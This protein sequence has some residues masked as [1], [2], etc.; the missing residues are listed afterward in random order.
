MLCGR[1]AGRTKQWGRCPVPGHG[2]Y[3][4]V[5]R[6]I[7]AEPVG[8]A[9]ERR[10]WRRFVEEEL[11]AWYAARVQPGADRCGEP[12]GV[13]ARGEACEADQVLLE[14]TEVDCDLA[15]R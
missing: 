6:E 1:M 4:E 15:A 7:R 3:C 8:R 13:W 14:A 9:A 5:S 2:A 12:L 11:A 10:A